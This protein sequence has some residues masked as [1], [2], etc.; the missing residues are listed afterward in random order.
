MQHNNFDFSI[1]LTNEDF[2]NED[3]LNF[4]KKNL[5][6]YNIKPQRVIFEIL[7][8]FTSTNNNSALKILNKINWLYQ[9]MPIPG[10]SMTWIF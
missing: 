1:N 8:S 10:D 5:K 4:I 6:K 2:N 3:I 7:E 9:G